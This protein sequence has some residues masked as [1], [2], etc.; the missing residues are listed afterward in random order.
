MKNGK[1]SVLEGDEK[2]VSYAVQVPA[3]SNSQKYGVIRVREGGILDVLESRYVNGVITFE[4]TPEPASY[5]II[6]Y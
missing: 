1:Y 5:A 2:T 6:K 3:G 4:T